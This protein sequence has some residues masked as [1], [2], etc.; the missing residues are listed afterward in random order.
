LKTYDFLCHLLVTEFGAR[1]SDITP[2]STLASVGLDS[3]STVELIREMEE[4][5]GIVIS[6]EQAEFDTLGEA[7]SI[8]DSLIQ[9]RQG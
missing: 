6:N 3:L 7:V 5:Y 4:E 9:A 2:E 1:P 8:V